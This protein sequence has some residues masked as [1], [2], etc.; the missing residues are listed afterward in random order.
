MG[1]LLPIQ[2]TH[3]QLVLHHKHRRQSTKAKLTVEQ[4]QLSEEEIHPR[5][6]TRFE[7]SVEQNFCNARRLESQEPCS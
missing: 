7:N 3:I 2:N 1:S 5:T 4:E 6:N